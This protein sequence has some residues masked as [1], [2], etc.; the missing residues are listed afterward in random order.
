MFG[1][2]SLGGGST[3]DR[4]LGSS[5]NYCYY[6]FC[7]GC[8]WSLNYCSW[9]CWVYCFLTVIDIVVDAIAVVGAAATVAA[10]VHAVTAAGNHHDNPK[11]QNDNMIPLYNNYF[12]RW[13]KKGKNKMWV[14]G[15]VPFVAARD[16]LAEEEEE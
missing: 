6:C 13:N 14:K 7:L 12:E 5:L 15:S 11:N 2:G 4:L 10:T 3:V 8:C 16:E 1:C 9:S